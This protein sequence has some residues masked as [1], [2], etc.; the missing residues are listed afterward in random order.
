[1]S[2]LDSTFSALGSPTRRA[3]LARLAKGEATVSELAEPFDMSM[4][5]VSK[6]LRVLESAGLV[7]Q[8][9]DGQMR[10]RRLSPKPLEEAA[11]WLARYSAF[12]EQSFAR[13]E[14]FLEEV[15]DPKEKP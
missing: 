14:K 15:Q 12:W 9:K 6:H 8:A 3:I 11:E 2:S 1:M 7:E 10:P 13:L 4:P 5:A